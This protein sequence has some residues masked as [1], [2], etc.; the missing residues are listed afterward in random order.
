MPVMDGNTAVAMMRRDS[1]LQHLPV[2]AMTAGATRTAIDEALAA[3]MTDC[4][5][6]PFTEEQLITTL[7]KQGSTKGK[8]PARRRRGQSF[9][10][11][12]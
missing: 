9:D 2:I 3:G 7:L 12:I 6:K 10:P 5:T 4:I 1:E 8:E 11:Q